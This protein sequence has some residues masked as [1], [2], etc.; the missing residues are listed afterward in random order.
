MQNKWKYV[1]NFLLLI[2]IFWIFL[3]ACEQAPLCFGFQSRQSR[4]ANQ[5][6][7]PEFDNNRYCHVLLFLIASCL[8][9]SKT[10]NVKQ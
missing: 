8:V 7:L 3:L 1:D 2:C 10:I 5:E 9:R 6:K 4:Q